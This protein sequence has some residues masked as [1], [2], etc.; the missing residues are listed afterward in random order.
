MNNNLVSIIVVVKNGEKY[1]EAAIK[2]IFEQTFQDY[3]IILVDGKSEDRTAEIAHSYPQITYFEQQGQ[4]IADAYNLGIEKANG[5]FISFISHD[6]MWTSNK[7]DLQIKYLQAHPKIQYTVAKIKFFLEE[8]MTLPYG[9][10]PE[11][12]IGEHIGFI[13]ETLVVRKELFTIIGNFNSDYHVAEDVDWFSRANDA[14]IPYKV[15]DQILLHKRVHNTNTS[16]NSPVND[17]NL[18]KILRQSIQRK[19]LIDR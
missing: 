2:S 13:M 8:E 12:L 19:R 3:E 4:G 1:L 11:L 14:G 6:D 9:F 5:E 15:I 7:L 17:K 18:L 10:R 16:L